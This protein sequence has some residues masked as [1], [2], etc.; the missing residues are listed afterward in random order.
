MAAEDVQDHVQVEAR[1]FGRTLELGDVPGP[2]L[3][4]RERQQLRFCVRRMNE[5]IAP[6][7]TAAVDRQHPIHRAHRA[8]VASLVQQRG[9]HCRRRGVNEALA[10]EGVQ[11]HLVF[12]GVQGQRRSRARRPLCP[13]SHQRHAV[14][15]RLVARRCPAPQ[16]HGPARGASSKG[17]GEFPHGSHHVLSPFSSSV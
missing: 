13:R 17:W 6:L 4:G 15:V 1:P 12:L 7:A 5:L 10:V 14:H 3:V 9:V 16:S 11:Q 8:E 2:H